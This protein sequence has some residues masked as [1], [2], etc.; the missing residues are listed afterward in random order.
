MEN[1]AYENGRYNRKNGVHITPPYQYGTRAFRDYMTGYKEAASE[2][3]G[4]QF[5]CPAYDVVDGRKPVIGQYPDDTVE[6][7]PGTTVAVAYQTNR[8]D[9]LHTICQACS[10]MSY[11]VANNDCPIEAE[12]RAKASGA[13]VY[14]MITKATMI[15]DT[16]GPHV[17]H[18]GLKH[19][20]HIWFLG[21]LFQVQ[22]VDRDNLRLNMIPHNPFPNA[23]G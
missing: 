6:I 3:I 21:K 7:R 18:I 17:K 2:E 8:G 13:P 9:T 22:R 23:A 16:A 5:A 11:A 1:L 14:W 20:Q 15:S 19:G 10:A 4:V 12:A